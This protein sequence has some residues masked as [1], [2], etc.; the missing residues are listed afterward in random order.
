[1]L[2]KGFQKDISA[3]AKKL[4]GNHGAEI[5][6]KTSAWPLGRRALNR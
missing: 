5:V 4:N 6:L 3:G 1:M 2:E